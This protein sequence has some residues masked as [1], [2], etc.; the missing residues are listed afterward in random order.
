VWGQPPAY[1]AAERPFAENSER[2]FGDTPDRPFGTGPE[3]PYGESPEPPYG[4]E[5]DRP[6]GAER[7]RPFGAEQERPFGGP[8]RFDPASGHLDRYGSAG[9]PDRYDPVSGQP[10]PSGSGSGQPYGS[11]P[12]GPPVY[13]GA[14]PRAGGPDQSRGRPSLTQW[15]ANAAMESGPDAG[16]P[17][18]LNR[19]GPTDPGEP[20]APPRKRRRGLMIGLGL[21]VVLLLLAA[22]GVVITMKLGSS[23]S[24]AVGD[25]VR[26]DGSSA[27]KVG[28]AEQGAFTVVAKVDGPDKCPDVNQPYVVLKPDGGNE[29]VLCLRPAG[30]K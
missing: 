27:K 25:C 28:C 5:P 2:P 3:Q 14:D 8:D 4:A 26:Q 10:D 16:T 22:A 17:D 19:G 18:A 6:Y 20:A 15:A 13:P 7:E 11:A 9:H 1:R 30:Q 12:A 29:Q 21:V 23:T 24:Y